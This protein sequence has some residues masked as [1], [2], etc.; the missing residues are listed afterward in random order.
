MVTGAASGIGL[1]LVEQLFQ[2]H[3]WKPPVPV[4][5]ATIIDLVCRRTAIGRADLM[6]SSR[7]RRVVLGRALIAYMGR[8][9]TTLSY[10]EIARALGRT[11]HSTVHTAEQRLRRQLAEDPVVE[12][13]E[14]GTSIRLRELVDQLRHEITRATTG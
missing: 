8:D 11:F 14:S 1:A 2:N 3:A 4:R 13:G 10:H 9:M 5:M 6:G 12:T 7:H